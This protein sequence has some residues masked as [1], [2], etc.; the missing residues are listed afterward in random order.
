MTK[1]LSHSDFWVRHYIPLGQTEST[2]IEAQ[3][4]LH[5]NSGS[6]LKVGK[7]WSGFFLWQ[8]ILGWQMWERPFWRNQHHHIVSVLI[9]GAAIYMLRSLL[10]VKQLAHA[11]PALESS[12][13]GDHCTPV[14]TSGSSLRCGYHREEAPKSPRVLEGRVVSGDFLRMYA[15][16]FINSKM[17]LFFTFQ[18][19]WTGRCLT[20]EDALQ[21]N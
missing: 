16:Y 4:W 12:L 7:M 5:S 3:L 9:P 20:M 10:R 1:A 19:L 14:L 6:L 11:E 21:Y 18:Y 15:P 17:Y 8:R 13:T 2:G